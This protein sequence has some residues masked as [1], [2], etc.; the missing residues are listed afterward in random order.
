MVI[1]AGYLGYIHETKVYKNNR[2]TKATRKAE[3]V[4]YKQRQT[5]YLGS[6]EGY[7]VIWQGISHICAWSITTLLGSIFLCLQDAHPNPQTRKLSML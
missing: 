1:R 5:P 6:R 4:D 3:W 7:R 2:Y